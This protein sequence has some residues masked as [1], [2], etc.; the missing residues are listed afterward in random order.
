[1][2]KCRS[3][4]LLCIVSVTSERNTSPEYMCKEISSTSGE[5]DDICLQKQELTN[6]KQEDKPAY[7]DLKSTDVK[8]KAETLYQ[9]RICSKAIREFD[10]ACRHIERNHYLHPDCKCPYCPEVTRR[11]AMRTH[12]ATVHSNQAQNATFSLVNQSA[13]FKMIERPI[14][15]EKKTLAKFEADLKDGKSVLA[16]AGPDLSTAQ[17]S[18]INLTGLQFYLKSLLYIYASTNFFL[19]CNAILITCTSSNLYHDVHVSL[20][21]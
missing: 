11:Q 21:H 3:P 10:D 15:D 17:S 9:C 2:H 12:M 16:Q 5:A 4:I 8:P 20:A 13:F 7:F 1:M 6:E 18:V 14:P 19:L